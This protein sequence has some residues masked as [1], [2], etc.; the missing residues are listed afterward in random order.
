MERGRERERDWYGWIVAVENCNGRRFGNI[1][2]GGELFVWDELRSLR[3]DVNA[4]GDGE[5]IFPS[6][7]IFI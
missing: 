3:G 6:F 7:S 2:M 5:Y 4:F 1:W